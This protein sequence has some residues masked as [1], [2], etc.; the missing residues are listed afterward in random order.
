MASHY[1][2]GVDV[3]GTKA[4]AGLVQLPEGRI[5]ARCLQA[6]DAHRGG[7]AVLADVMEQVRA[8]QVESRK[9]SVEP[10]VVG[11]AAAEL[12]SKEGSVLSDATIRW[13]GMSVGEEL[14]AHTGLPA[15]I[16]ADVRAAARAEAHLGAGR[17]FE[18]FLYITIGTGISSCLVN[19]GVPYAGARGLTG[20]FASSA[21]L[22][23]TDE[24][25]LASG[26]PLEQ[27]AGGPALAERCAAVR[28]DRAYST[29]EVLALAEAGDSQASAIVESAGQAVGA[30]IA[31]LVNVVDPAAVI[32]GGGLGLVGGLYFESLEA[33]L[34]QQVW[35]EFHQDI[36]LLPAELGVDAGVIGA[37]L[38]AFDHWQHEDS[39]G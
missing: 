6:T 4:A 25:K 19:N 30:A 16:D 17:G 29:H 24:G 34:R 3:G 38:A 39:R 32:I 13:K 21:G 9:L 11:L 18:S 22:M 2:I 33:A 31:H 1:A 8:L 7:K 12:V 14:Q 37:A 26:P 27:F 20:T 10:V 28:R 5:L 23:P 36:P 35:S 15:I